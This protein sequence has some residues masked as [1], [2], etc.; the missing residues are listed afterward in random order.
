[1]TRREYRKKKAGK[2]KKWFQK[3]TALKVF[4]GFFAL[5][6]ACTVLSRAAASVLVAQVEVESPTGGT[7]TS[8][9]E[10]Q[11]EVVPSDEK[12]V[13]LWAEQQVEK[14]AAPGTAVKKG[15]CLVQF[16]MEY[17]KKSIDEKNSEIDQ[18]KLQLEQQEVAA[19]G[20]SYVS[21]ADS[22]ARTLDLA[23]AQLDAASEKADQAQAAYDSYA[24]ESEEEENEEE[25]Q[26][27]KEALQAALSERDAAAQAVDE[28][29]NA[30]EDAAAQ[31]AAQEANNA[32][33]MESARLA[34]EEIQVQ[35]DDAQKELD[36]LEEYQAAEGRLCA[37]EDCVVLENSVADGTVTTG[38]E[39]IVTG[40]GE[41]LLRGSLDEDSR[42]RIR[43]GGKAS[44]SMDSGERALDVE[45][46]SVDTGEGSGNTGGSTSGNAG[47]NNAAESGGSESGSSSSGNSG[48]SGSG[49]GGGSAGSAGVWYAPVPEGTEVSYGDTFTWKVQVPL[50]QN[51]DCKIPLTALRED[52]QGN[53]CL[54]VSEESSALGTVQKAERVPVTVLEKNSEEAAVD[55]VLE[56]T[57]QVIVGSE[58]YV[59]EGDQIRIKG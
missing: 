37:E 15:D 20:S 24:G 27:L 33:A 28:A 44:V 35:I 21:S 1:M 54:I 11:G 26:A 41:W 29:Q 22:A 16:R 13:F 53:Y 31:D 39:V 48:S 8:T 47:G 3:K 7:V 46:R 30:Y 42:K 51:Y 59:E 23:K 19:R 9:F 18:L 43:E 36:V 14:S 25:R 52:S 38:A 40:S 12:Q 6:A 45:I 56:K 34:G 50:E 55:S 10:G 32:S 4:G 57:D 2:E 58:K 5:M 49:T 17:L